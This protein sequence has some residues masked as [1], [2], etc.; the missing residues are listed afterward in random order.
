M[1]EL[2]YL[3]TV[4]KHPRTIKLLQDALEHAKC[5]KER[6]DKSKVNHVTNNT[7]NTTVAETPA[8]EREVATVKVGGHVKSSTSSRITTRIKDYG[9]WLIHA[10]VYALLNYVLTMQGGINRIHM[11]RF[12]LLPFLE[13]TKST[14]M[15]W[16][17][18]LPKSMIFH[19][20]SSPC[21]AI[22]YS[23]HLHH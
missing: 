23:L 13:S 7:D 18:S 6:G 1:D 14:Q 8:T 20:I 21:L 3:L 4:S 9:E 22:C 15:M 5:P 17:K 2:T 16:S 12:I 19:L 10:V 11:L